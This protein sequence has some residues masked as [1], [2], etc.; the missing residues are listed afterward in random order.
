MH[1]IPNY[2]YIIQNIPNNMHKYY[3]ILYKREQECSLLFLS[4]AKLTPS[5]AHGIIRF[6]EQGR[7]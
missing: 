5:A 6:N 3:I 1:V 2:L 4:F 7:S